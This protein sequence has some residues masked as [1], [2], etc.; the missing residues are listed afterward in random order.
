MPTSTRLVAL[1][2]LC[3]PDTTS[4]GSTDSGSAGLPSAALRPPSRLL[5][6]FLVSEERTLKVPQSPSLGPGSCLCTRSRLHHTHLPVSGTTCHLRPGIPQTSLLKVSQAAQNQGSKTAF[7][8][9]VLLYNLGK[10]VSPLCT[11]MESP[12]QGVHGDPPLKVTVRKSAQ[13]LACG[14]LLNTC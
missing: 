2:T 11:S 5:C 4:P 1:R 10:G 9:H 13:Y 12:A 14:C 7:I 6:R 8:F 3:P